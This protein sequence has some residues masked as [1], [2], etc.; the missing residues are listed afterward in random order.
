MQSKLKTTQH[1][2]WQ[3]SAR[4]KM[5]LCFHVQPLS[6]PETNPYDCYNASIPEGGIFYPFMKNISLIN[7]FICI[8]NSDLSYAWEYSKPKTRNEM[9]NASFFLFQMIKMEYMFAI[10]TRKLHKCNQWHGA[11]VKIANKSLFMNGEGSFMSHNVLF[12]T[13]EISNEHIVKY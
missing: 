5:A 13:R 10:K 3:H 9:K 2:Q 12:I 6:K 1:V 8:F 7:I 11:K 4:Q